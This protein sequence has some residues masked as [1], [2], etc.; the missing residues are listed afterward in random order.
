MFERR[1]GRAALCAAAACL[2]LLIAGANGPGAGRSGSSAPGIGPDRGAMH[3][4]GRAPVTPATMIRPASAAPTWTNLTGTVRPPAWENQQLAY[5]A[6][7][8]YLVAVG[9]VGAGP[10]LTWTFQNGSWLNLSSTAGGPDT[11]VAAMTYDPTAGYLL[12]VVGSSPVQTWTFS[13]GRWSPIATADSPSSVDGAQLVY[14]P[15]DGYDLLVGTLAN[16][17]YS[18][19]GGDWAAVPLPAGSASPFPRENYGVAYDPA[20]GH[21]LLAFGADPR[22]RGTAPNTSYDQIWQYSAGSWSVVG[23]GGP[24]VAWVNFGYCY[25]PEIAGMVAFGGVYGTADNWEYWVNT[26]WAVNASG[27]LP[28]PSAAPSIRDAGPGYMAYDP[29]VGSVVLLGGGGPSAR[30]NDTWA[31]GVT[32]P[33]A[34]LAIEVDPSVPVPGSPASFSATSVGGV[35]PLTYHWEFGDGTGSSSPAPTHSFLV[36]GSYVVH[37]WANDSAGHS[38]DASRTVTVYAPLAVG[39]I[40]SDRPTGVIGEA[41]TFSVEPVNGT[42]PYSYGWAFGDGTSGGNLSTITHIFS[43]N[44]VFPVEVTVTDHRG[45]V[46]AAFYNET[47]TVP[48]A[49][50]SP[51]GGASSDV[52][53]VAVG[54]VAVVAAATIGYLVVRRRRG[55]RP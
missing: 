40:R 13:S 50:P 28:A 44:G 51:L 32:P 45:A 7:D 31:Y 46:V 22:V 9:T 41:V 42:A 27:T 16:Q 33:L 37:L 19:R 24:Y 30:F 14:D 48:G 12:A 35:P 26:T 3:V 10:L 1:T 4:T 2:L 55:P 34:A 5:D 11:W 43:T 52:I 15:A 29:S 39:G 54:G 21:V 47:V 20:V 25:D 49:G 23:G 18:F 6:G 53:L 17:T 36:A 38:A 8:G